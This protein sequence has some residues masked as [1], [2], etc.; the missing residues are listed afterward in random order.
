MSKLNRAKTVMA[1]PTPSAVNICTV[2]MGNA[3][4]REYR[5]SIMAPEADAPYSGP[6]VSSMKRLALA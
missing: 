5:V 1:Q 4:L 3:K 6:Y 2:N